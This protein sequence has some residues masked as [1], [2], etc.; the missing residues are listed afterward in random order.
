MIL[1]DIPDSQL[2]SELEVLKKIK[3][4][5]KGK[6]PFSLVRVG[7]GENIVLG[8]YTFL[9]EKEFMN[10]YWVKE[11]FGDRDKGVKLPSILLREQMVRSLKKANI[12][13]ICWQNKKDIRV[14]D[15]YKRSLTNKI[16]DHYRIE[17]ANLCHVFV[18]RKIIS[19]KVFWRLLHDYRVL[20]ISKWAKP[21]AQL[22]ARKYPSLKP[23]IVAC[24]PFHNHEQIP[25]LLKQVG[26]YRFDLA[27]VSAGVN[28]VILAQRIAEQTGK[29]AID[30]GKSM[31]FMLKG[32]PKI[33]PWAPQSSTPRPG[34][35]VTKRQPGKFVPSVS[36]GVYIPGRSVQN[37]HH[38][39]GY[40]APGY[41]NQGK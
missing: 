26:N 21:F 19:Y 41:L 40:I 39:Q 24:L 20:L 13:G 23:K 37:T 5:L 25:D 3:A 4:A 6:K 10:T 8:Q 11:S 7:D 12:I 18:N 31:M 35:F 27:L 29:V 2:L 33:N 15:R 9:P 17:P 34:S 1:R 36:G 32:S 28:A 30:F 16:F 22:I 38:S 14:P